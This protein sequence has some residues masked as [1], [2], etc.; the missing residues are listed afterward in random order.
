M[1]SF[2]AVLSLAALLTAPAFANVVVSSP[3]NGETTNSPAQFVATASTNTCTQGVAAM[4]IYVDNRLEYVVNGTSLNTALALA[5]GHHEAVVQEW[6]FCGGATK[7]EVPIVVSSQS[8]VWVTSPSNNAGVSWLTNVVATATT[9]CRQGVSAMGIYVNDQLVYVVNG[10]KLNTQMNLGSGTQRLVVQEWDNCGGSSGSPVNVTVKGSGNTFTNLQATKGWNSWGQLAPAYAD[11]DAP[12]QGVNWSMKQNVALPSLTGNATQFSLG[13]T[14]P[15]SDVL[16]ENPLIGQFSTQGLPDTNHALLP[17]L[18]NFTYDA[19]FYLGNPA[20]T[21]A[22]EFDVNWFS[23][24]VGMTWGT[25]CRIRGG[26]EWDIW[27]NV[28]AKWVPTGVPCSPYPNSWNHVTVNVQR[29]PNDTLIFQSITLNGNTANINKTYAPFT[30]PASWY[31]I[32]VNYQMDGDE[33]QDPIT[34]YL[35]KFSFM[36]W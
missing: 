25:E 21:Q 32:T 16:F 20:T 13:G 1:K 35:D 22:A 17:A 18:H 31:G 29:G 36:Y 26:H 8:G 5:D 2:L 4:G 23:N 11:C 6:D 9:N 10:E 3:Q 30:V 7:T 15:Y 14:T 24:T 27:D 34:S 33:K 19:W 12:C 28:N